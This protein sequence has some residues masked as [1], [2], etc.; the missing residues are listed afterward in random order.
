[1]RTL[2]RRF[3]NKAGSCVPENHNYCINR[4]LHLMTLL[5]TIAGLYSKKNP[6]EVIRHYGPAYLTSIGTMSSV[7]HTRS[8]TPVCRKI[9]GFEKGHGLFWNSF[10]CKY[11]F[12]RLSA[13]RGIFLHD[14]IKRFCMALFHQPEL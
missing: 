11:T 10:V 1:M 4:T 6:I 9:K 12:V 2:I 8:C 13:D 14:C 3:N 5:Y 7:C